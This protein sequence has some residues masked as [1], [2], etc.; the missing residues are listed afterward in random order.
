MTRC[1]WSRVSKAHNGLAPP[2]ASS[3][4]R[5]RSPGAERLGER[6][7][8]DPE[9]AVRALRHRPRVGLQVGVHRLG[10]R[11]PRL[12][13]LAMAGAQPSALDVDLPAV[14]PDVAER[15]LEVDVLGR[16]LHPDVD[17]AGADRDDVLLQRR[18]DPAEALALRDL[19]PVVRRVRPPDRAAGTGGSRWPAARRGRPRTTAA[20]PAALPAA[21]A[22]GRAGRGNRRIVVARGIGHER[23][24]RSKRGAGAPDGWSGGVALLEEDPHL[25]RGVELLLGLRE[26]QPGVAGLPGV[27]WRPVIPVR[28]WTSGGPTN[29]LTAGGDPVG[30]VEV[31]EVGV[32]AELTQ[33]AATRCG[34]RCVIVANT[35]GDVGEAVEELREV[36]AGL[37][38][39]PGARDVDRHVDLVR[40]SGSGRS[41]GS[42]SCCRTGC[43]RSGRPGRGSG[44]GPAGW[45]RRSR[46]RRGWPGRGRAPSPRRTARPGRARSVAHGVAKPVLRMPPGQSVPR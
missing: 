32:P 36:S 24:V 22:A 8:R 27:R 17:R 20:W 18:G 4:I 25:P 41:A 15:R 45:R 34:S 46:W 11:R 5:I 9:Q 12:D 2:G 39:L 33:A 19:L 16:R 42:R 21:R 29:G 38:V 43:P 28:L 10:R 40:R 26:R 1:P 14:G 23:K 31:E 7:D 30:D 6:Q 35:C 13:Q 44:A 37:L 3:V